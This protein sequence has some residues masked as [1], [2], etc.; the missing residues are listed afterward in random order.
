MS[1]PARLRLKIKGK[2]ILKDGNIFIT[3]ERAYGQCPKYIQAREVESLNL[4]QRTK[5]D[6]KRSDSLSDD[7]KEFVSSSDTFFIA[8]YHR[9]SGVDVSHRGGNPGF[10]KVLDQ[11]KI[12]FPDYPG[13][14]M[15]NTLGNISVNPRA[16]LLFIDFNKGSTI[17]LSGEAKIIWDDAEVEAFAGAERLIEY[18]IS[19]VVLTQGVVPIK[20][21]FLEYS[22]FNPS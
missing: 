21:E 6:I 7:L 18:R 2:A 20:W 22:P 1:L 3:I 14:S 15:F 12:V 19:E 16:S 10:I 4:E 13:N 5:H 9:E 11:N 17:K 8:T